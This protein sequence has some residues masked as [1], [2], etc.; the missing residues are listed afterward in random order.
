MPAP[1]RWTASLA[2]CL[3]RSRAATR[4]RSG[5]L[6]YR[7]GTRLREQPGETSEQTLA[8]YIADKQLLLLL[9]NFEQLLDAAPV[10]SRLL[11]ICLN[12][13]LHLSLLLVMRAY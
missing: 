9:D 8:A 10:T 13:A 4:P 3:L 6:D 2:G 11:T 12:L 5:R 7:S 1:R